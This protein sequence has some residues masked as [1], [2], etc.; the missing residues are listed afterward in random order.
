MGRFEF[1]ADKPF[2]VVSPTV[3]ACEK[4]KKTIIDG[5]RIIPHGETATTMV[6]TMAD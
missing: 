6:K 3:S 5:W 1:T 2:V 4:L